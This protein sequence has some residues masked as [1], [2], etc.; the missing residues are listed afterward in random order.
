MALQIV[1]AAPSKA[2][3]IYYRIAHK[4]KLDKWI[5][6]G[7]KEAEDQSSISS[8]KRYDSV[9]IVKEIK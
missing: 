2:P 9:L 6:Q 7:W 3:G 8:Q 5:A 1:G 4:D